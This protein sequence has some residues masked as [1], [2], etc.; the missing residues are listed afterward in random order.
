MDKGSNLGAAY[1]SRAAGAIDDLIIWNE[2]F[3]IELLKQVDGESTKDPILPDV[4]EVF[5]LC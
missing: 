3:S 2:M 5:A 1:C 4:A